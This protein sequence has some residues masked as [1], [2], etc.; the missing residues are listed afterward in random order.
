MS[1]EVRTVRHGLVVNLQQNVVHIQRVC[2]GSA[3]RNFESGQVENLRFLGSR[4]QFAQP[5]LIGS[6]DHAVGLH[7]AELGVLDYHRLAFAV[8]AHYSAGAGHCHAHAFLQIDS[9]ADNIFNLTA[10]DIYLAD[11]QFIR[12]GMGLYF[13]DD[14]HKHIV[15]PAGQILHILHLYGRHGQIIGQ[16]FQIHILRDLY[17]ILYPR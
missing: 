10:A 2:K 14:T 17:I 7:A 15:K 11:S 1:P 13:L 3:C 9:T 4:K 6:A 8:P 5:N 16:L 12:I